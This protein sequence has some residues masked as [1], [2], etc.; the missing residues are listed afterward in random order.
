[1]PSD[2]P[3]I[4]PQLSV[5]IR[6]HLLTPID[7]QCGDFQSGTNPEFDDCFASTWR[8]ARLKI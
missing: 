8:I 6:F 3:E 1:M 5:S 4:M 7:G 2:V